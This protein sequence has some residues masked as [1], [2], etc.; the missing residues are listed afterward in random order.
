MKN[1]FFIAFLSFILSL[2]AALFPIS[3]FAGKSA[4]S[5]KISVWKSPSCN[6]CNDWIKHLQSQG[7]TVKTFDTGNAASR[8]NFGI[9]NEFG[10]CHTAYIDKYA[11]EGHVP[12]QDIKKLLNKRPDAIGLAV[13]GM[14]VGSPGMDGVEYGYRK[15]SFD[16]L[17]I[18]KDGG[19]EVFKSY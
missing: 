12:A 5:Y 14:P 4:D 2:F 8:S 16:V 17:L 3:L 6:C 9:P 19:V 1:I 13:P 7:F 10:S 15:D 18:K 11:I